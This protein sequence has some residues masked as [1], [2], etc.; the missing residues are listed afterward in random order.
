MLERDDSTSDPF[1][2]IT[3][4]GEQYLDGELDINDLEQEE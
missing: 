2:S 1:Y 3:D 4:H